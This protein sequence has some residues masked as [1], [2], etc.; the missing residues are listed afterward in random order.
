MEFSYIEAMRV[1][2]FVCLYRRSVERG[3][4]AAAEVVGIISRA[5]AD[6]AAPC[7]A[8]V[9]YTLDRQLL[10]AVST[11][12]CVICLQYHIPKYVSAICR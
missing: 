9:I 10:T 12:R 6:D 1:D 3:V 7:P 4:D 2:A 11:L 5:A 8:I